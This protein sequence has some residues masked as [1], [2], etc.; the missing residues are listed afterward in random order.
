[1]RHSGRLRKGG[2]LLMASVLSVACG[3]NSARTQREAGP[4]PTALDPVPPDQEND[5]RCEPNALDDFCSTPGVTCP[6]A[7]DAIALSCGDFGS[8]T[9]SATSCGSRV[10]LGGGFS[11][12]TWYFDDGDQL[13]GAV[14]WGDIAWRCPDGRSESSIQ[15]GEIC[16]EIGSE[17][18]LCAEVGGCNAPALQCDA[19]EDCPA[20]L[21]DLAA[22]HCTGN[23]RVQQSTT[24]CGGSMVYI[25]GP[26]ALSYCF[27]P[28][29]ALIG[30]RTSDG[31]NVTTRGSGCVASG[32]SVDLC[33]TAPQ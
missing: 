30:T 31:G 2:L 29:G 16:A 13:I 14:S 23:G 32:G 7:P 9:R 28:G 25:A 6:A 22:L 8:T 1:M 27:D 15:Y 33:D 24:V 17:T 12:V 5:E 4:G 19:G 21:D 3:G 26:P 20:S 11:G 10:A 18:D